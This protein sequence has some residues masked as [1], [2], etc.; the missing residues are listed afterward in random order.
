MLIRKQ[1]YYYYFFIDFEV[2]YKASENIVFKISYRFQLYL[3]YLQNNVKK[4]LFLQ[5]CN[6]TIGFIN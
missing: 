4:R 5:K 3:F 2:L 1:S 6:F